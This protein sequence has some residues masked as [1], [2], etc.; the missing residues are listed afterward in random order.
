MKR[1]QIILNYIKTWF[2]IDVIATFPYQWIIGY[3]MWLS[4]NTYK[5][6]ALL[7]LLK[8]MRFIRFLRLLRVLKLQRI[9][10]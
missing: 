10:I 8:V 3:D 6:P 2:F 4:E 1:K 9:F 7:R 5:T